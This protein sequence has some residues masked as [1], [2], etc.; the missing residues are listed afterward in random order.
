MAGGLGA[1]R[2]PENWVTVYESFELA[3]RTANAS[4]V[5]NA[6]RKDILHCGSGYYETTRTETHGNT[7]N[8]DLTAGTTTKLS[9]IIRVAE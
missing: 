4:N 5:A 3:T 1:Y 9:T 7:V 8:M 6:D 2:K